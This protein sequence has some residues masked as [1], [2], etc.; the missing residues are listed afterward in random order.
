MTGYEK[1]L[2]DGR[3]LR[4]E[5]VAEKTFRVRLSDEWEKESAMNRYGFVL[6]QPAPEIEAEEKE[7]I[8][9]MPRSRIS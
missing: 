6:E 8:L 1:K 2:P 7:N 4:V 5:A 9:G 3:L